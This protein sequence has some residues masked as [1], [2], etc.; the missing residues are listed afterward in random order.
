MKPLEGNTN[1]NAEG[2]KSQRDGEQQDE[3]VESLIKRLLAGLCIIQQWDKDKPIPV[4]PHFT[5]CSSLS[6][7]A[8]P[9]PALAPYDAINVHLLSFLMLQKAQMDFEPTWL[10]ILLLQL[11]IERTSENRQSSARL[12]PPPLFPGFKLKATFHPCK[13]VC[14]LIYLISLTFWSLDH[15]TLRRKWPSEIFHTY[16]QSHCTCVWKKNIYQRCSCT[17]DYIYL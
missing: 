4:A 8:I 10:N 7:R 3:S 9:R 14:F 13:S 15:L 2:R 16:R 6:H 11:H 17:S 5:G 1:H 12:S